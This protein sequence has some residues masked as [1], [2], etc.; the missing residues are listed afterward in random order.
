[1]RSGIML[2]YPFDEGRFAKWGS[3]GLMQ[4]K[5]D[6]LRCRAIIDSVGEVALLSSQ[7]NEF[8]SV[9][10]IK[11]QVKALG[12]RNLE[13]DGELYVHGMPFQSLASIAK[14]KIG[15]HPD[16]KQLEYHMFDTVSDGKQ[17]SRI[18]WLQRL[19]ISMQSSIHIVK[20]IFIGNMS[21]L[22]KYYTEF[23]AQGYEG[24]IIRQLDAYY[25]RKRS[26]SIMKCKPGKFD[27]YDVID[28]QEEHSIYGEPKGALGA[29]VLKSEAGSVFS[30]GSGFTRQQRQDLWLERDG[31]KGRRCTVKYQELTVGR[32]V[33]R[34]PVFIS[35]VEKEVTSGN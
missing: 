3:E 22:E 2:C 32:E 19:N 30:V 10:H 1:M 12:L 16:Y 29:L 28:Y 33:P 7:E 5:L 21:E 27:D 31:L 17:A 14:T 9:P 26:T 6:G 8:T 23:V 25:A 24:F 18:A 13:L 20:T 15:L 34:F 35:L 4:P 11:E